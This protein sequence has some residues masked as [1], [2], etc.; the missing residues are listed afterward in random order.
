MRSKL[1]ITF[2]EDQ[3]VRYYLTG[4]GGRF[5]GRIAETFELVIFTNLPLAKFIK[6]SLGQLGSRQRC[7]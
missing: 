4:D 5:F 1:G 6:E 2:F 7:R 3:I